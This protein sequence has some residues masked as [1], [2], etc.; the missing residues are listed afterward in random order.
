MNITR[1][2][3]SSHEQNRTARSKYVDLNQDR[4]NQSYIQR[5][6]P[7]IRPHCTT[8]GRPKQGK[9][10]KGEVY[11]ELNKTDKK[12][13]AWLANAIKHENSAYHDYDG[14]KW[15]TTTQEELAETL[16]VVR[17]TLYTAVKKLEKLGIIEKLKMEDK[18][19]GIFQN[20]TYSYTFTAEAMAQNVQ[21]CTNNNKS[22]NTNKLVLAKINHSAKRTPISQDKKIKIREMPSATTELKT[23]QAPTTRQVVASAAKQPQV[24]VRRMHDAAQEILGTALFDKLNRKL[25]LWLGG[26]RNRFFPTLESWRT[27]LQ[28]VKRSAYLMGSQFCLTVRWLLRF[29]TIVKI[30][31]GF[32]DSYEEKKRRMNEQLA[33]ERMRKAEAE[34]AQELLGLSSLSE[35][36]NKLDESSKCKHARREILRQAGAAAY[37]TWFKNKE[38]LEEAGAVKIKIE[39]N[40]FVWDTIQNK[41]RDLLDSLDVTITGNRVVFW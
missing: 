12:L 31:D 7:A 33:R 14:R 8:S 28:A 13:V 15:I 34:E 2:V 32:Y 26:A 19:P 10:N 17:T 37:K 27:F 36:I 41:F 39:G 24:T 1:Y 11:M 30:L 9:I 29:D 22:A 23:N 16:D 25:S 5:G 21:N 4:H 20:H 40:N 18:R 35:E 6:R 3:I 38:F